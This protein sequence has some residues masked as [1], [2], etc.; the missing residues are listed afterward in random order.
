MLG[1]SLGWPTRSMAK[2]EIG[3][4]CVKVVG[5]HVAGRLSH[6]LDSLNPVHQRDL[7]LLFVPYSVRHETKPRVACRMPLDIGHAGRAGV[8]LAHQP[9][10]DGIERGF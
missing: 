1:Q 3:S 10:E 7:S 2:Q 8:M 6:G 9:H 5:E 4:P